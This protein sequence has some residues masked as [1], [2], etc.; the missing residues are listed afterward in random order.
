MG[1][2]RERWCERGEGEREVGRERWCERGEGER[3]VG[4]ERGRWGGGGRGE[5]QFKESCLSS[6]SVPSK[7]REGIEG[8]GGEKG[9]RRPAHLCEQVQ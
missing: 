3:E 6:V 5:S 7:R 1:I 8:G 9:E 4:R 2:E